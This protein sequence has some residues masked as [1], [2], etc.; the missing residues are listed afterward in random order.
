MH[1]WCGECLEQGSDSGSKES[2]RNEGGGE[3]EIQNALAIHVTFFYVATRLQYVHRL[4]HE[5]RQ[6]VPLFTDGV[7]I[8][9]HTDS[10]A[11][12]RKELIPWADNESH[13]VINNTV[14]TLPR[15]EI[16]RHDMDREDPVS[17]S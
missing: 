14:Y 15:I 9:I 12:T 7:D 1:S 2:S 4:L 8:F 11:L 6:Y 17:K 13:G 10:N 16:V 5:A 3:G